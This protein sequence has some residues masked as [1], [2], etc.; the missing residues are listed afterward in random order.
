[1]IQTLH[2]EQAAAGA[3]TAPASALQE[4]YWLLHRMNPLSPAYNVASAVRIQ[5]ALDCGALQRALQ[6]LL[7]RH[8]V[9]RTVLREAGG[10]LTQVVSGSTDVA[11]EREDLPGASADGSDGRLVET[12]QREIGRAS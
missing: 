5:G 2:P 1:M 9:L 12:L 3:I 8:D 10:E 6:R 4:Q 11:I 7:A